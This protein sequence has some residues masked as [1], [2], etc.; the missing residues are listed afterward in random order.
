MWKDSD[1]SCKKKRK[2]F[3][4]FLAQLSL[5][6]SPAE[7]AAA[8]TYRSGM[9]ERGLFRCMFGY[10][11]GCEGGLLLLKVAPL[12]LCLFTEKGPLFSPL[13]PFRAVSVDCDFSLDSHSVVKSGQEQC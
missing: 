13:F 10:S 5:D 2:H 7:F 4:G 8:K 6:Q 11:C 1:A 3:P 9:P 12:P